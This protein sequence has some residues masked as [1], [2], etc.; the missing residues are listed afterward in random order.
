MMGKAEH[1]MSQDESKFDTMRL[2]QGAEASDL[3][4]LESII[5]EFSDVP[6]SEKVE[7]TTEK[8]NKK[9]AEQPQERNMPPEE[10]IREEK[11][12]AEAQTEKTAEPEA[13]AEP[14]E[15]HDEALPIDENQ[16]PP[17]YENLSESQMADAIAQAVARS[18]GIDEANAAETAVVTE[19]NAAEAAPKP[20]K[21]KAVKKAAFPAPDA[22]VRQPMPQTQ[23]AAAEPISQPSNPVANPA[24]TTAAPKAAV[25]KKKE[26]NEKKAEATHPGTEHKKI[27]R[28]HVKSSVGVSEYIGE[29]I[30]DVRRRQS[31]ALP[32]PGASLRGTEKRLGVFVGIERLLSPVRYGVILLMLLCIG[33][34]TVGWMTLGFMRGS[35]AVNISLIAVLVAMIAGWQ[36]VVRG[37]KDLWYCKASYETFLLLTTVLTIMEALVMKN[38]QTF[39][40]LIAISWAV[41]GTAECLHD[42]ASL[43]S[44]RAVI[45]GRG[46]VGVRTAADKWEHSDVIGKAPVTTAGFVRHQ[47]QPDVWHSGMGIFLPIL[48]VAAVIL[49][50]YLSVKTEQNYLTV[51]VTILDVAMPVSLAICCA[52]PYHLLS[53]ALRGRGAVAGWFGLQGLSGKKA[54]L[55]YD[56]DLFPG[57]TMQQMGVRAYLPMDPRELVSMGASMALRANVGFRTVFIKLLRDM[58]GE[59]YDVSRFQIQETG[60][61]GYIHQQLVHLGSYQYMQL[62]GV[63][64][65][66]RAPKYGVYIAVNRELAGL[67][68]VKY[69]VSNGA[70][71]G[72]RRIVRE[73]RLT[74][75]LVTRNF[76]VNPGFVEH[77]FKAPVTQMGCPKAETRRALSEPSLLSRGVTCAFVLQ[78][79]I[80]AYSRTVSGARRVYRMG[81]WLTVLTVLIGLVLTVQTVLAISS[82]GA[83]ISAQRLLILNLIL[84]LVVELWARIAVRG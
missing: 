76:C 36:S 67:F 61:E 23:Q 39:L 5:A 35:V 59:I 21:Q 37:V 62:M 74:P 3:Y 41:T 20:A 26:H 44:L 60:L 51:L 54:M 58:N 15:Q 32:K 42:Q 48:T 18:T 68:G 80:N 45:T 2:I 63:T 7:E 84:Y 12:P 28:S 34:R 49:S 13:A 82:G 24:E 71:G 25:Q 73:P 46:R 72:F 27:P 38:Q 22:A 81:M 53:K 16:P 6:E 52:R 56:N 10:P 29:L 30:R 65:P 31:M 55:V 79:G 78:E 83:I 43:T 19:P 8:T 33:G 17:A 64:L 77:W 1:T 70:V 69:Q 40:P 47:A 50:A 75:L 11:A 66:K 57:G 9:T 14:A 4:S